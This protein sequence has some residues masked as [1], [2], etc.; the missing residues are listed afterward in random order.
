MFEYTQEQL[1]AWKKKH[2]GKVFEVVVED[3]KAIL[4]KPARQDL[5][6]ASAGSSQGKDALKFVELLMKQ[7]WI[8]GDREILEDDDYFLGAVPVVEA[9]AEARRRGAHDGAVVA[10]LGDERKE[11]YVP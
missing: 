4:K 7:C 1:A 6:Y 3:K 10:E 8:D 11:A 9:L 5:S 2:G